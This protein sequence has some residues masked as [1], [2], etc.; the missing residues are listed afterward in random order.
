MSDALVEVQ[1]LSRNYQNHRAVS[2]LSF[3]LHAGEVLGFLGPN[4][5]GK[6]TTM[7]IISGNLAPTEGAVSIAG[8]DILESP[9]EAKK[10]LGYLPEHP[11]VYRDATVF[12]YLKYCARLH[13]VSR[14]NL[15]K[16]IE[17]ALQQ[18]GLEAVQSRLIGNLSKGYQQR[19]G[20]AQAILHDPP[21]VILDE[22]TVGLDP[23]QMREIRQLIRDLGEQ[24]SVI[25][26]THILSEVQATCDRVQIIRAGELIY[27][28]S[29]ESLN[30]GHDSTALV[31]FRKPPDISEL[32][33]VNGVDHVDPLADSRFRI[34]FLPD[35][36]PDALVQLSVEQQWGLF[37]LVPE[38]QSLEDLFIEL[39]QQEEEAE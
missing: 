7:Q 24:R 22:P 1:N 34:Y 11:P 17:R 29:I 16:V 13:R 10:Q 9:R 15:T 21:V 30:H 14:P 4:G 23:I 8:F 37:E 32:E 25:L 27:N 5:A 33:S 31:A 35:N 12:E 39:T 3:S 2:N 38:Q 20:I 28:A 6:S 36:G 19:I 18:C 26:S